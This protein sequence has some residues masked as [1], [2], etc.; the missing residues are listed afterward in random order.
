MPLRK[1]NL[2]IV[3]LQLLMLLFLF[4]CNS[5][6]SSSSSTDSNR[7]SYFV[8]GGFGLYANGVNGIKYGILNF[9]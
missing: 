9:T 4:S 6:S 8:K 3:L 7:V 2:K 5:N 1:N